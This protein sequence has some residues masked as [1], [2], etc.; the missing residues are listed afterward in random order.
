MH[1][2]INLFSNIY[3]MKFIIKKIKKQKYLL[4]YLF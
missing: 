2:G 1:I 3:E 4:V